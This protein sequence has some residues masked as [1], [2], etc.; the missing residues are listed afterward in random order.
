MPRWALQLAKGPFGA[1]PDCGR[2][3]F[4]RKASL[5]YADPPKE[6]AIS[7][8]LLVALCRGVVSSYRVPK[9]KPGETLKPGRR[10][11][12]VHCRH[13]TPALHW[14]EVV[15]GGIS[16]PFCK[17]CLRQASYEY[18]DERGVRHDLPVYIISSSK[19]V[20][21]KA[22]AILLVSPAK[23]SGSVSL[24]DEDVVLL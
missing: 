22:R 19:T 14:L 12:C 8:D 7:S 1:C 15:E 6:W 20:L 24:R 11:V 21:T 5:L 10:F 16:G 9:P 18:S 13:R 2:P 3:T 17:E 4:V 23:K